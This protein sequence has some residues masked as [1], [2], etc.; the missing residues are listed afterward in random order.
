MR[1]FRFIMTLLMLTAAW[2]FSVFVWAKDD[3]D[4]LL[5][6]PLNPV[7]KQLSVV[8]KGAADMQE[9]FQ[10]GAE[11]FKKLYGYTASMKIYP[12]SKFLFQAVQ[13]KEVD[14]VSAYLATFLYA[15]NHNLP[16]K[17][18][19]SISTTGQ[20]KGKY[21]IY[22]RKDSGIKSV[23]DLQGKRFVTGF[24]IFNSI[25]D[26]LP[27]KESYIY[28]VLV[29]KILAGNGINKPFH[30]FFKELYVLPVPDESVAYAVLLK[31]FDVFDMPQSSFQAMKNYDKGF[32]DITPLACV[33]SPAWAP[34]MVRTD[35]NP[36]IIKN[37]K[38]YFL[39]VNRG[40]Q[41][42]SIS[43]EFKGIQFFSAEEKD[44]DSF[45][46]W[47]KEAEQKGWLKEFDE[48][49]KNMPKPRKK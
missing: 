23:K 18:L 45:F 32:N 40:S 41:A 42:K 10:N 16:L 15:A 46:Q 29:R 38:N 43:K 12:A 7:I 8:G 25:K 47:L 44:Y 5:G 35:V 13:N 17:P 48:I 26:E 37:V 27:P 24:P 9:I 6:F 30:V 14:F 39:S 11:E 20:K 36:D 22:V 4:I 1:Y 31:K 33:E 34:L 28:W 2:R 49:M 19:V 3:K 21:C